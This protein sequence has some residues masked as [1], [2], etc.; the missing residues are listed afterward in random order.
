M[1]QEIDERNRASLDRLRAI[2]AGLLDEELLHPI[3]PP[4]TAAAL[5]A[6][7]AF[8]DRF[9]HARWLH[10]MEIGTAAPVPIEDAPMEMINQAALREWTVIPPRIAV[11]ECLTAAQTIDHFIQQLDPDAISQVVREGRER[12]VDRSIHR[13]EHLDTIERAFPNR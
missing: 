2:A 9:V 11:E 13:R 8:W 6:H 4:W 12:L 3:D 1:D 10:A 7:V 5:F